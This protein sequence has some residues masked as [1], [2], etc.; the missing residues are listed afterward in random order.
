[1]PQ[2][3]FKP[4]TCPS[5]VLCFEK[6][7]QGI[8][9]VFPSAKVSQ[10]IYHYHQTVSTGAMRLLDTYTGQF[11]E[12]EP[13]DKATTYAILS[14]TWDSSGE[15][16]QEELKK[17]QK[18]WDDPD[19]SPKIRNT[20]AFARANGY[21]YIWIDSC[22]IDKTSSAE[23]S[24]AIN[25]MYAWYAR[26]DV[27]YAYLAD[28]PADEDHSKEASSFH[29]SRWFMR[30][31]TL[32]ELLAPP[33]LVFLSKD[34][35]VLGSKSA[36][37]ELVHDITNIAI[38]AL[39][40]SGALHTFS[41]AQ[42]F[43]WATTRTTTR[44][45]Y[46]VYSLLGIFD[47]NMPTLYGEGESA[48][49]RLQEEILR[50]IP[51]QSLF[52]STQICLDPPLSEFSSSLHFQCEDSL[53]AGISLLS[54]SFDAFSEAGCIEAVPHGDVV[55]RFGHLDLPI[56]DYHFTP[57]GIRTQVTLIPLSR[58]IHAHPPS[59]SGSNWY[60]VLLGCEHV[61]RPD[62]LLARVCHIP[63]HT[64]SQSGV[65]LL[66]CG[67]VRVSTALA[68]MNQPQVD[69]SCRMTE[70]FALG[71]DT[72]QECLP[73]VEVRTVYISHPDR[74][75]VV[76]RSEAERHRPHSTIHLL[77]KRECRQAL[78][79]AHYE[80]DFRRDVPKGEISG[81]HRLTI[82]G[83]GTEMIVVEYTHTLEDTDDGQRLTIEARVSGTLSG[84]A[85]SPVVLCWVCC[86]PWPAVL[87]D[88]EKVTLSTTD[89]KTSKRAVVLRLDFFAVNYYSIEICPMI[90]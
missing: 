71:P 10:L 74:P 88:G 68:D 16:T 43:S 77:L 20:C 70:V 85:V 12:K 24:E 72:V 73:F 44:V 46:R 1:M 84:H 48:F 64:S 58:V 33:H 61:E 62:H 69:T 86:R 11:V 2:I 22:C 31:W 6:P 60:L 17:I 66:Y 75:R 65:E 36:L 30:G 32:Q 37:A 49:H 54:P 79:R 45:E 52:V 3:H 82:S 81:T 27:C 28:V 63:T 55:R 25:S 53:R 14:H 47:I 57:L 38:E 89:G 80:V 40:Q 51:D 59:D 19:L 5:T 23:L 56:P 41:V 9:Q 21:R 18:L 83:W 67:C 8:E 35:S 26:A 13:R 50:R 90:A 7:E 39:L 78:Q 15:P 42:R 87:C 34:W 76:L 29:R 4:D